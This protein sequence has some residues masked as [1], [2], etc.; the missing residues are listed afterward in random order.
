[1]V[2]SLSTSSRRSPPP[3]GLFAPSRFGTESG[4]FLVVSTASGFIWKCPTEIA[5]SSVGN[6]LTKAITPSNRLT[7]SND[8]PDPSLFHASPG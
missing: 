1:V 7:S 6:L 5:V 8:M 3:A 4:V 2:A